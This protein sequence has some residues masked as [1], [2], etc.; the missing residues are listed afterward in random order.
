MKIV[1]T[2]QSFEVNIGTLPYIFRKM[3]IPSN[4]QDL[5][6]TLYMLQC[7]Y[8]ELL[9]RLLITALEVTRKINPSN[10]RRTFNELR[11]TTAVNLLFGGN[12][13]STNTSVSA[14]GEILKMAK[15]FPEKNV[16]PEIKEVIK[17]AEKLRRPAKY[18]STKVV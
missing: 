8:G 16:T 7:G 14:A 4:Q 5:V 3:N 6:G 10:I 15:L 12:L 9:L 17:W 18:K 1:D 13:N 2:T 11:P